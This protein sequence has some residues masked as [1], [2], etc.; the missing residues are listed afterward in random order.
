MSRRFLDSQ[1]L[2]SRT[3]KAKATMPRLRTKRFVENAKVNPPARCCISLQC[4][5][6]VVVYRGVP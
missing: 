4:L 6:W 3:I 2:L 5:S 1:E